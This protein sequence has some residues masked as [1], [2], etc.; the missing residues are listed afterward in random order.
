[1]IEANMTETKKPKWLIWVFWAHT[2]SLGALRAGLFIRSVCLMSWDT[3]ST[4]PVFTELL[5]GK[6]IKLNYNFELQPRTAPTWSTVIYL[7][8]FQLLMTI[9]IVNFRPKPAL[10]RVCNRPL[11]ASFFIFLLSKAF[12]WQLNLASNKKINRFEWR[13]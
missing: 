1:M 8:M 5:R 2:I 11:I 9:S 13:Y 6:E 3:K 12:V 7:N 4:R 10:S